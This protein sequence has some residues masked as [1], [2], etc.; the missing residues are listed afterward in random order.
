MLTDS[1]LI[2][3]VLYLLCRLSVLPECYSKFKKYMDG[4]GY[5]L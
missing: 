4:V 3:I 2:F 1:L 5:M